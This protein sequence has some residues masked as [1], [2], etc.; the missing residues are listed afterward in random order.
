MLNVLLTL[1][2][3]RTSYI[4]YFYLNEMSVFITLKKK[5]KRTIKQPHFKHLLFVFKN[6]EECELLKIT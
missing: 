2:A 5:K 4:Y 6:T 3:N 1:I